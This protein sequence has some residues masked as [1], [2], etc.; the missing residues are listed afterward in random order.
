MSVEDH[1]C[2]RTPAWKGRGAPGRWWRRRGRKRTSGSTVTG[3]AKTNI[4]EEVG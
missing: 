3:S 1:C 2:R 4:V